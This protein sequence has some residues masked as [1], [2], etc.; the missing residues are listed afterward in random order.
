MSKLSLYN[1]FTD[2]LIL[3]L[4]KS[5]DLHENL[6]EVIEDTT[7]VVYELN[8][9]T[10]YQKVQI[11]SILI[12]PQFKSLTMILAER[13]Y[14]YRDRSS[15]SM[16]GSVAKNLAQTHGVWYSDFAQKMNH[17]LVILYDKQSVDECPDFISDLISTCGEFMTLTSGL[18]S[19]SSAKSEITT[20]LWL[21]KY[22][23]G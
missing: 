21:R 6:V 23:Q 2:Y 11:A 19:P 1:N 18:I 10:K 8:R 7:E 12:R 22:I 3:W 4:G 14:T 9:L 20:K 15:A 5:V 16:I 17:D 13:G